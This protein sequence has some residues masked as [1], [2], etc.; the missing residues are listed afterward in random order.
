MRY[1][2]E[3]EYVPRFTYRDQVLDVWVSEDYM[4]TQG[5]NAIAQLNVTDEDL[6]PCNIV[7]FTIVSGNDGGVFRIDSQTGTLEITRE[8]DYDTQ[9]KYNLTIQATNTECGERR[10]SAQVTVCVYVVDIDD[11]HPSFDQRLYTFE[12]DELQQPNNFVQLSCSDTDTPGA[13]IVYDEGFPT[14]EYP[15]VVNHRDGY[16]STTRALD[17]EQE[18]SYHLTFVCYNVLAPSI[19][20]TAVVKVVVNPINEYLP[21]VRPTFAFVRVNYSS[22]EGLLI[23]STDSSANSLV[24]LLATDRDHGSEHGKVLFTF[25]ENRVYNEYFLL[26]S[27]SGNLTQSR[28]FDFDVCSGDGVGAFQLRIIV[29]DT[30][31]DPRRIDRCPIVVI[32]VAIVSS[33]CTLT[34]LQEVYTVNV[35]ESAKIGSELVRVRCE[36]PGRGNG[37]TLLHSIETFSPDPQFAQTLRFEGDHVILQEPLDYEVVQQ[38]VVYLRCSDTN[39]QESIASVNIRVLP[40]NDI[41]PYFEKS[42]YSFRI[43]PERIDFLPFIIG[44]VTAIDEDQGM[45][46][47]LTYTLTLNKFTNDDSQYFTFSVSD[48]GSV[49]ITM[50]D[51]PNQYLTVLDI[52]VSD[53]ESTAQSS[54]LI[55]LITSE[56][57]DPTSSTQTADQCGMLCVVLLIIVVIFMV[58]TVLTLSTMVCVCFVA[59]TRRMKTKSALDNELAID[60]KE[61]KSHISEYAS[62]QRNCAGQQPKSVTNQM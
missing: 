52:N 33:A 37:T 30:L 34:F 45:I 35:S 56:L 14:Q 21:E 16:V 29:C 38:F 49:A 36:V 59:K 50:V 46:S 44:Y 42:L 8:L 26:D 5:L 9:R 17:Y 41:P 10:Y 13:Q 32:Y 12:F 11:E 61:Y 47:N 24:H 60:L 1:Q 25:A 18:T 27:E 23:A 19:Q 22:P 20:D 58:L 39:G 48:N 31:Q 3:N 2:I 7:T 55:Q 40:E 62:L 28:P 43:H 15:F 57:Q 51:F 53:G 4:K 54:I 6:E